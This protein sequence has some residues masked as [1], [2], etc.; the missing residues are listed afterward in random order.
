MQSILFLDTNNMIRANL[1]RRCTTKIFHQ[2]K[3]ETSVC[4]TKIALRVDFFLRSLKCSFCK[5]MLR[6]YP[7]CGGWTFAF[8]TKHILPSNFPQMWACF[9]NPP[10]WKRCMKIFIKHILLKI[11]MLQISSNAIGFF[12]GSRPFGTK[13]QL[14]PK[15]FGGRMPLVWDLIFEYKHNFRQIL[16]FKTIASRI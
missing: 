16:K 13:Y 15:R 9:P 10:K 2:G 7:N 5:K 8:P 1:T 12:W 4:N 14:F 11:N 6:F 3:E